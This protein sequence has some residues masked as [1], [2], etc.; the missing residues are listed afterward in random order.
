[1]GTGCTAMVWGLLREERRA[2]WLMAAR[3]G[4]VLIK[5]RISE[6]LCN[7]LRGLV[8]LYCVYFVICA[9]FA[10]TARWTGKG[11]GPTGG[12]VDLAH[13]EGPTVEHRRCTM[14]R[15]WGG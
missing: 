7:A 5:A 14:G 3:K 11:A 9:A 6:E 13:A 15:R 10:H 4:A 1:L 12:T 8:H 2:R